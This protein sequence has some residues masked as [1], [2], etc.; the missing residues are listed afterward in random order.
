MFSF[1]NRGSTE[2]STDFSGMLEIAK[3]RCLQGSLPGGPIEGRGFKGSLGQSLRFRD[4]TL[5]PRVKRDVMT[6]LTCTGHPSEQRF[7]A[8]GNHAAA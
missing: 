5:T 6:V 3:K 8:L 2:K 7:H 4:A 1:K